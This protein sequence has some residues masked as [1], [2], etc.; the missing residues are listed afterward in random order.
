MKKQALIIILTSI[1]LNIFS[2]QRIAYATV[3]YAGS[4]KY[5]DS[6]MVRNLNAIE[7]VESKQ[8]SYKLIDIDFSQNLEEIKEIRLSGEQVN[9]FKSLKYDYL[10][11][12]LGHQSRRNFSPN[13]YAK[14]TLF[15]KSMLE[16]GFRDVVYYFIF[17]ISNNTKKYIPL[18][19]SVDNGEPSLQNSSNIQ[20]FLSEISDFIS[21]NN[22]SNSQVTEKRIAANSNANRTI[23]FKPS[24]MV[25][26]NNLNDRLLDN[27]GQYKLNGSTKTLLSSLKKE[28]EDNN[29]VTYGFESA[30]RLVAEQRLA[31]NGTR[32]NIMTQI[33]E[34]NGADLYLSFEEVDAEDNSCNDKRVELKVRDYATSADIASDILT[35]IPCQQYSTTTNREIETQNIKALSKK[36]IT[37]GATDKINNYLSNLSR[38]GR[39]STLTFTINNA[40]S[41]NFNNEFDG[42]R[43]DEFI[44]NMVKKYSLN[45]N[46]RPAGVVDFKMQFTDVSIPLLDEKTGSMYSPLSFSLDIIKELERKTKKKFSRKVIGTNINITIE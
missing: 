32:N 1:S 21:S 19:I 35:Y 27:N 17:D 18:T 45:G 15:R 14:S 4:L 30:L 38:Y 28:L 34:A 7:N 29:F 31:N 26:P 11:I 20:N 24:I 36:F 12:A 39:K 8:I 3:A 9:F 22:S 41:V 43:L 10:V 33:L 2:Q 6:E 25:L 23:P 16:K 46:Y 37:G 13:D 40:S 42:I 5:F 44:E